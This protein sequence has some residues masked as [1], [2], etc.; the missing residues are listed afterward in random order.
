M[1][2]GA[3]W[4]LFIKTSQNNGQSNQVG[5]YPLAIGAIM[6]RAKS[7][8]KYDGSYFD[9]KEI[10][11]ILYSVEH[12]L[13]HTVAERDYAINQMALLLSKVNEAVGTINDTTESKTKNK[14]IVSYIFTSAGYRWP[15]GFTQ[16]KTEIARDFIK[17]KCLLFMMG[18]KLNDTIGHTWVAD[19]FVVDR[20]RKDHLYPDLPIIPPHNTNSSGDQLFEDKTY[21]HFDWGYY[22]E[23]NGYYSGDI[24]SAGDYGTYKGTDFF[25]VTIE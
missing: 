20:I 12:N 13:P 2:Q 24:F 23:N 22:G 6:S 16:F 4:N 1:G 8:L 17:N 18:A 14:G 7:R 15:A 9:F 10:N 5:C 11:D 3:P 25:P 19:G 21:L